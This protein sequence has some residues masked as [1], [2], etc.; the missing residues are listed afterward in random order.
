MIIKKRSDSDFT[1]RAPQNASTTN[2]SEAK[3]NINVLEL[4]N[5]RL[6]VM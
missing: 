4:L 5:K 2:V 6:E 1:V 3:L